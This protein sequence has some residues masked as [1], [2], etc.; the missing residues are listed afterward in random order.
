M[1]ASKNESLSSV[2]LVPSVEWPVYELMSG[3]TLDSDGV[4]GFGA[5]D[6]YAQFAPAYMP[7][8]AAPTVVYQ[9]RF[10]FSPWSPGV[11]AWC[12]PAGAVAGG[13]TNANALWWSKDG[14]PQTVGGHTPVRALRTYTQ[15]TTTW[16]VTYDLVGS[17][18][19]WKLEASYSGL[20]YDYYWTYAGAPADPMES[21]H[22]P[23]HALNADDHIHFSSIRE[24]ISELHAD[25]S[26][27]F[28]TGV[29]TVDNPTGF[30][31]VD[32]TAMN[33]VSQTVITDMPNDDVLTAMA[34]TTTGA[35]DVAKTIF[36][37]LDCTTAV[38]NA[39]GARELRT[40]PEH[41]RGLGKLRAAMGRT[42][43]IYTTQ[44]SGTLAAAE[45]NRLGT[46]V[47]FEQKLTLGRE[48]YRKQ[49]LESILDQ[50]VSLHLVD[51]AWAQDYAKAILYY[52]TAQVSADHDAMELSAQGSKANALWDLELYDYAWQPISVLNGAPLVSKPMSKNQRIAAAV[53]NG[54]SAG[55]QIGAATG[56]IAVGALVGVAS[57]AAQLWGMS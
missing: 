45:T 37:E 18:F 31:T 43:Q 27:Q 9:T 30:V 26:I 13:V 41:L 3:R 14:I 19:F 4:A 54:A 7:N 29:R 48:S 52:I 51:M 15:S 28:T 38:A 8:I 33:D 16:W 17:D 6:F 49:L 20:A 1:G 32:G 40:R 35:L 53:T 34:T 55:L 44:F 57:I 50:I 36:D 47:D 24:L 56:N 22:P 12:L 11:G 10:R 5:N 21:G 46:L 25:T 39:V 42:G 2:T 23:S